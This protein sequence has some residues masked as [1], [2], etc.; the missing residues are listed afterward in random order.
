MQYLNSKIVPSDRRKLRRPIC[1][2]V[3]YCTFRLLCVLDVCFYCILLHFLS[4][5]IVLCVY[6]VYDF[7]IK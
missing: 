3:M 7:Y 5:F 2:I 4:L 1:C 6:P